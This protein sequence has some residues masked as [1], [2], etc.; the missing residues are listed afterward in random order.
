[1]RASSRYPAPGTW[2]C[3][4]GPTSSTPRCW[5]SW[6]RSTDADRDVVEDEVAALVDGELIGPQAH[7]D[8]G[9]RLE[10]PYPQHA[11]MV[12]VGGAPQAGPP[13]TP[14]GA[15]LGPP[16][17]AGDLPGQVGGGVHGAARLGPRGYA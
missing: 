16:G 14:A 3:S 17:R 12:G 8:D 4:N 13:A 9:E 7:H 1:M 10:Y 11:P 6:S 2:R 15:R 5:T